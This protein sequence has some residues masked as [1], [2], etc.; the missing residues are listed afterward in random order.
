MIV[1]SVC[2]NDTDSM[3]TYKDYSSIYRSNVYVHLAE[4]A[5]C[6]VIFDLNKILNIKYVYI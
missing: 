1:V 2:V 5:K 4:S 6:Y 3:C